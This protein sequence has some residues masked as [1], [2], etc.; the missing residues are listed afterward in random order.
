MANKVKGPPSQ[1]RI[2]LGITLREAREAA[3]LSQVQAAALLGARQ[4]KVSGIENATVGRIKLADI[5]TLGQA[6]GLSE[7]T[8]EELRA[9]A[10]SPYEGPGTWYSAA[11]KSVWWDQ[12]RP[13]EAKARAI[14]SFH[15]QVMDGLIQ[16]EPY[17]RR[18]MGLYSHVDLDERTATR[19]ERQLILDKPD[20]PYCSFML[21]EACFHKTMGTPEIMVAQI[22]HLLRLA[23]RPNLEFYV[24]PFD[25]EHFANSFG[26]TLFSF[27]GAEMRD[28]GLIEHGVGTTLVDNEPNLRE[29]TR[30]WEALR[31]A[32]L[33]EIKTLA[34]MREMLYHHKKMLE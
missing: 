2:R 30:R 16:C 31:G 8:I 26:F 18:Q 28:F 19:L 21:D 11:P 29:F 1:L 20:P 6:Y 33:S 34:F 4:P 17:A 22:E 32:A 23:D 3:C 24:L 14:R 12:Q 5:E 15:L 27:D 7:A 25:A 13:I 10:R 9:W